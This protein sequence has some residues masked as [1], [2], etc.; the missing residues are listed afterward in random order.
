[1]TQWTDHVR[2]YSEKLGISY[3]N[4]MSAGRA[5]YKPMKGGGLNSAIRKTKNTLK[6]A[7]RKS[8]NFIN[9][10]NDTLAK[11]KVMARKT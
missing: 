2:E 1:M 11:G 6:T 3:K 8:V 9:K 7:E 4:A 10:S 5:S